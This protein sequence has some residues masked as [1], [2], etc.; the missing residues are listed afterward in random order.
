VSETELWH[1]VD[2]L[3]GN[4]DGLDGGAEATEATTQRY[5]QYAVGQWLMEVTRA[6]AESDIARLQESKADREDRANATIFQ[7]IGP[8]SFVFFFF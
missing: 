3:W 6:A 5:R 2:Q 1:L 4:P 7:V 8:I